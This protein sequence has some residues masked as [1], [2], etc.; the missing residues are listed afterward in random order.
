MVRGWIVDLNLTCSNCLVSLSFFSFSSSSLGA[1]I[2][3]GKLD[4]VKW[5]VDHGAS[6]TSRSSMGCTPMII[7]SQGNGGALDDSKVDGVGTGNSF[8]AIMQY[9]YDKGAQED[10]HLPMNDGSTPMHYVAYNGDV[11]AAKWLQSLE[12]SFTTRAQD[13]R[14]PMLCAAM[15]GCVEMLDYLYYNGAG[16][17]VNEMYFGGTYSLI[18]IACANGRL[19]ALKWLVR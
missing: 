10:V 7:A 17:D 4:I 5:F 12:V 19:R 8:L 18:H 16:S 6:V 14:T 2:A 11:E 13:S 3:S 9:L 1:A 15:M